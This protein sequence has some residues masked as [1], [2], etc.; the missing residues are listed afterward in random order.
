MDSQP[1]TG[2][3]PAKTTDLPM[4]CDLVFEGSPLPMIAVAGAQHIVHYAN[5]AACRL[6]VTAKT[7]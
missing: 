5:P 4:L 1:E 6:Q 3:H 2:S 7:D